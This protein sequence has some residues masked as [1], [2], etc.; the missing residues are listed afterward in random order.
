MRESERKYI[1]RILEWTLNHISFLVRSLIEF[2]TILIPT[3]F[4]KTNFIPFYSFSSLSSPLVK[5]NLIWFLR[6]LYPDVTT[7][8][9]LCAAWKCVKRRTWW[10][11]EKEMEVLE[12]IGKK[13]TSLLSLWWFVSDYE[14]GL[15][16]REGWR[17]STKDEASNK[18]LILLPNNSL[19]Q[20]P[21]SHPLAQNRA[22]LK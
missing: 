13:I 6:Y 20:I 22:R 9:S 10:E 5:Y 4:T 12:A 2:F 17:G 7:W 3:P 16:E 15:R 14:R 1:A 19:K 18:V 8:T 11:K 21:D